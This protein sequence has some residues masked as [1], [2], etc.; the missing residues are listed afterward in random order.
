M[1][2]KLLFL[3][4]PELESSTNIRSIQEQSCL[5]LAECM[6]AASNLLGQ[7]EAK[8][9]FAKTILL[10]SPFENIPQTTV[11]EFFLPNASINDILNQIEK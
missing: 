6:I 11:K 1:I 2:Y 8:I 9:R 5:A 3:D 4:T 7:E 10:I